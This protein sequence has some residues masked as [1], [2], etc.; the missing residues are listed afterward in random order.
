MRM[1][2]IVV[3]GLSG[4]TIFFTYSHKWHDFR[5]KKYWAQKC[6]L[7]FSTTLSETFLILWRIH[8][9]SVI[10]IHWSSCKV[11]VILVIFSWSV[12]YR[13]IF[14][15]Y[16]NMKFL[17][18]FCTGIR[19]HADEQIN[20]TELRVPFRNFANAPKN[21]AFFPQRLF[22]YFMSLV[23]WKATFP[24]RSITTRFFLYVV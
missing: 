21:S 22:T 10:N 20:M 5:K 13:E 15:T 7:I 2:R 17:E 19:V 14:D 8:R 1:L 4:C 11:P 3:Y 12:N 18:S 6:V 16:S 9:G 23:V 24:V